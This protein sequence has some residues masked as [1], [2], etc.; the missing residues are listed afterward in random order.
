MRRFTLAT[1]RTCGRCLRRSTGIGRP[2][3]IPSSVRTGRAK[4]QQQ[5]C[6]AT[7]ALSRLGP[8]AATE[9]T[10]VSSGEWSFATVLQCR[11]LAV[12]R[13]KL[14]WR[15]ESCCKTRTAGHASLS[16]L[17]L[18]SHPSDICVRTHRALDSRLEVV[19]RG[20]ADERDFEILVATQDLQRD[21]RTVL[22]CKESQK[23]LPP[24]KGRDWN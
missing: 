23:K 17:L 19:V 7:R 20:A 6:E 24:T 1:E 16:F 14:V 12:A 8:A 13:S 18:R 9:A 15:N 4:Q 5:T 22:T 11:F 3:F 21:H 2:C 10:I